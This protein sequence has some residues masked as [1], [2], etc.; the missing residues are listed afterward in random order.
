LHTL[1]TLRP[2][3]A[4]L[5]ALGTLRSLSPDLLAL[6]PRLLTRLRLLALGA[7]GLSVLL[8]PRSGRGADRQCGDARGEKYPGHHNFS[9]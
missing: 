2:F 9:F 7:R 8:R 6:G 5:D 1:G 4:H 3:R